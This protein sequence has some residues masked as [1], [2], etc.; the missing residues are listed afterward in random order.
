MKAKL[1][2]LM[3]KEI[4]N[5]ASRLDQLK[6]EP[7]T[8]GRLFIP[9][10]RMISLPVVRPYLKTDVSQLASFFVKTGYLEGNGFFYV[11]LQDNL[12]HTVDVTPAVTNSWS[13]EWREVNEDFEKTLQEDED[14]RMFSNKMFQ[15]WDGN[16]RL[17]AWYPII[18]EYHPRDI[19]W[20]YRVES[21]ILD[22]KGDIPAVIA[23]LHEVNW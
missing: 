10:C 13:P 1:H 23:A 20:H 19:N 11:A 15:V 22:P 5:T 18:N 17:Q 3:E 6:W 4:P 2:D 7:R 16:H 12:G 21:V 8:K 9:L 14:L